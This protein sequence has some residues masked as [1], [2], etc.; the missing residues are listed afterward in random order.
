GRVEGTLKGV[1]PI[2]TRYFSDGGVTLD[3]EVPLDDLPPELARG[4]AAPPGVAP[5]RG[6]SG[7]IASQPPQMQGDLLV[8]VARGEAAVLSDD[9]PAARQKAIDDALR[10]AVEMAAGARVTSTTEVKDFQVRMD[11]VVTHAQGF[12]RR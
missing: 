3:V 8:Q 10:R 5:L 11:Q 9:K 7:G 12:V 2:K 6:T 1:K 4:L